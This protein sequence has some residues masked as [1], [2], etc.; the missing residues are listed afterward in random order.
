[1]SSCLFC[2]I[3]AGEIPCQEIHADDEILAFADIDPQAPTHILVIP[4]RHIGGLNDLESSDTELLGRMLLRARA[5]AAERGLTGPGYRFV[6]NSGDEGG[7]TVGHLHLHL[8]GG[9]QMQWP[10]G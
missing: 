9:R 10:P 1:M 6:I 5:I 2:S 4:R 3:A 7:Q 8:L